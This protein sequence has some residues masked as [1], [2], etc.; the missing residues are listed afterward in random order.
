MAIDNARLYSAELAAQEDLRRQAE[1]L[2]AANREL[3]AFSYSVSHDLR[4]P[5]RAMD[6]F[7]RILLEEHADALPEDGRRYLQIVRDSARQMG[8]LVDDLLAFSRLGR[9]ALEPRSIQPAQLARDAWA[10]LRHDWEDRPVE[11][12]VHDLPTAHADP[13]LLRLVFANLLG[14]AVKF[15]RGRSP[16]IIEVGWERLGDEVAYF[17]HDNG[18]GF[19]MKYHDK[20]FGVFQRLH[21]AEEF[22]GTGVG[23]AIVQ[24]IVHR[25]GGR[26]WATSEPDRGATFY[27]TLG[28][29]AVADDD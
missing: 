23:L 15:S 27:F 26:V 29:G 13:T 4:A 17:V 14:N 22:E 21:R 5:L 9:Q 8:A 2:A 16:A 12:R 11:F 7:S 6:G 1:Q 24:R 18:V 28:R 3:E 19:D 20:L 25:H 10:D